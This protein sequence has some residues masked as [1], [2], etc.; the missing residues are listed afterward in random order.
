M[1]IEP[2]QADKNDKQ[3]IF[4]HSDKK[5]HITPKESYAE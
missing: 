4:E 3:N 1:P 5:K 2:L